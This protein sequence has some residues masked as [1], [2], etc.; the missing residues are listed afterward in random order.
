MIAQNQPSPTGSHFAEETPMTM[1]VGMEGAGGIVLASDT[2]VLQQTRPT[3]DQVGHVIDVETKQ[4]K[5]VFDSKRNIA[6]TCADDVVAGRKIAARLFAE[7]RDG[8][9][10]D[11]YTAAAAINKIADRVLSRKRRVQ[12]LIALQCPTWHLLKY[13][14]VRIG[15]GYDQSC[16]RCF[17]NEIAGH[18]TNPAIFIASRYYH[19]DSRPLSELIPLA[20][21]FVLCAHEFNNSGVEGLDI[22]LCD[23]NGIRRLSDKSRDE[24]VQ[25]FNELEGNIGGVF[26]NYRQE[27]AYIP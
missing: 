8:D 23:E 20:A 6:V 15:R 21:Y 5:I 7:L 14:C 26:A 10:I 4:K 25:R 24:L 16:Q 1:Q 18:L 9:L 12:C 27:Y 11:E 17:G 3:K 19:D 13:E 22:V 2:K